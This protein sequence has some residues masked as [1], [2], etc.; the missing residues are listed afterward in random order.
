[1]V[2]FDRIP[3]LLPSTKL[4]GLDGLEF[5]LVTLQNLYDKQ[6]VFITT[7]FNCIDLK[8]NYYQIRITEKNVYKTVMQIYCRSYKF[9][10]MS[11]K[12]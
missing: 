4:A 5:N 12:L 7:H 3:R 2:G 11:F 8:S 10:V 1:M 9:L 6:F